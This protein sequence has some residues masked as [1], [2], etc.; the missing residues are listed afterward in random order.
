MLAHD[1]QPGWDLLRI[2]V[3]QH[4]PFAGLG[5]IEAW[6]L[7]RRADIHYTRFFDGDPLPPHDAVDLLI[8]M[9]GPMSVNDEVRLPWLEPE[10]RFVRE[11]I[12]RNIAVLGVCLGAQLIASALG[13]RV[14][15]GPAKEIGWFPIQRAP[16]AEGTFRFPSECTVF[17]W[18]GE[19]FDLPLGAA[20]LASSAACENQAFQMKRHVIGLQC[21]LEMTADG[22]RRLVEACRHELV[23][24]AYVQTKQEMLSAPATRYQETNLLMGD[25]LEYLV[26]EPVDEAHR[27]DLQRSLR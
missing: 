23:P 1:G 22:V 7:E 4:V 6:L 21:H 14:Y 20:R 5:A 16:E 18:H 15:S 19:T 10:K 3:L 24:A 17:H 11:A 13:S 27:Y 26:R 12:E 2:H 8:V 25:V 9:G